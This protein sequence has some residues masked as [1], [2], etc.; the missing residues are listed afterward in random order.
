MIVGIDLGTTKSVVGAYQGGKPII[1]PDAEGRT[2]I[3]STVLVTPQEEIFAGHAATKHPDYLQG[4]SITISSVKRL[5]G[6]K[7]ET[8]W[9]WWKTYPQEISAL[10]LAQLKSQAEMYLGQEVKDAVIAIPSHFDESQRR[11]TKEAAVIAG[12]SPLRLL[13]E[14]TAAVLTYGHLHLANKTVQEEEILVFD[15]GGGTLD[16][17]AIRFGEGVYEVLSIEGDS[18]LGGDDF[19][20][21]IVSYVLDQCRQKIGAFLELT[22][23]QKAILRQA[24]TRVKIELSQAPSAAIHYPSF[25]K[26]GEKHAD[27]EVSLDRNTY[28]RLSRSLFDR[29]AAVLRKVIDSTRVRGDFRKVLLIGGSSRI[30]YVKTMI[31]KELRIEPFHAM[32]SEMSVAQGATISAGILS[33]K[34]KEVLLLDVVP[35]TYGIETQGGEFTPIIK[36][37]ESIPIRKSYA[38]TTTRDNQRSVAIRVLQGEGSTATDS[39]CLSTIVLENIPLA[40]KGVPQIEVTFDIDANMTLHASA[41]DLATG[42]EQSLVVESPYG[43]N[44][45]Q[46]KLMSRKIATWF[47]N[48]RRADLRESAILLADAAAD[49]LRQFHRA[50]PKELIERLVKGRTRLLN[51]QDGEIASDTEHFIS[52]KKIYEEAQ[53]FI[54]RY[55]EN[56]KKIE[57]LRIMIDS[58][59]GAL[60]NPTAPSSTILLQGKE[61]LLDYQDRLAPLDQLENLFV[62]VRTEYLNAMVTYYC[63]FLSEFIE[64]EEVKLWEREVPLSISLSELKNQQMEN[65]AKIHNVENIMSRLAAHEADYRISFL[66]KMIQRLGSEPRALAYFV[67]LA[68]AFGGFWYDEVEAK[69]T[70]PL[71]LK[72]HS[73]LS[74]GLFSVGLQPRKAISHRLAATRLIS[75]LP[76]FIYLQPVIAASR[77]ECSPEV[78]ESLL[79]YIDGHPAGSFYEFYLQANMGLKDEIC[80]D[81][82]LLLRLLREP[83]EES[84]LLALD[85]LAKLTPEKNLEL[86]MPFID[87]PSSRVR[88]RALKYLS[89]LETQSDKLKIILAKAL[90]DRDATIRLA[91]Y[92]YLPHIKDKSF[93]PEVLMSIEEE[94]DNHVK[95]QAVLSLGQ[96]DLSD[97][98]PPLLLLSLDKNDELRDTA[99]AILENK[100]IMDKD[101][102]KLLG[103]VV[104]VVKTKRRL[105]YIDR[106]N[107]SR[108]KK[109]ERPNLREIAKR[110]LYFQTGDQ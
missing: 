89:A 95:R 87:A 62:F 8:G 100:S 49:L 53:P 81:E 110:L 50:L 75:R 42:K 78:T 16:V 82:V 55:K 73:V 69:L 70:M 79:N 106:F 97:T 86:F 39:L 109:K 23:S 105:N 59:V 84:I 10:I 33:G 85:H 94:S 35:G 61:L 102:S 67:T 28:E 24:A 36:K 48:R 40:P 29:A 31:K 25:L 58:F 57:K 76:L 107:I 91:T 44:P 101:C 71:V 51:S 9:G 2:S 90:S 88:G 47:D 43:L 63:D 83:Q 13:N 108:I 80:L 21:I 12:L 7:G 30:P 4:K 14:A 6:K 18:R 66:E 92:S 27:L 32:D 99:L 3:P 65:L 54:A 74:F 34:L 104:K 103:L 77:L 93:L 20:E 98:V 96:L 72:S 38:A 45:A 37:N 52:F 60:A 17:S 41:K 64:S 22:P 1:I 11:A 46:V 56:T 5:M 15:F 19:D 26:I 68:T